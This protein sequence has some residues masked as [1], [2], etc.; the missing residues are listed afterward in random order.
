MDRENGDNDAGGRSGLNQRVS[1]VRDGSFPDSWNTRRATG[2]NNRTIVHRSRLRRRA[3]DALR[4]AA[5]ILVRVVVLV[6]VPN[7]ESGTFVR[8][9]SIFV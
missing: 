4:R 7:L 1:N 5:V 2:T 9:R 3:E 8:T 6:V